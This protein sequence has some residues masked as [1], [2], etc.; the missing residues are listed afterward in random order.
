MTAA[1]TPDDSSSL[2]V[3]VHLDAWVVGSQSQPATAFY[4]ADY[5]R[6]PQFRALLDPPFQPSSVERP[7]PGVRLHW[8]LPDALTHGRTPAAG[9]DETV[10]PLVPNRWLVA[11]FNAG[12]DGAWACRLWV[13]E[14]DYT[15]GAVGATSAALAADGVTSVPL[16]GASQLAVGK[17]DRLQ[18][19]SPDGLFAATVV[20][21]EDAPRGAHAVGI[22][23]FDFSDIQPNGLDAGSA[24]QLLAGSPFL[25]PVN[26]SYM[27]VTDDGG[28]S[29]KVN[30]AS[31]GKSRDIGSWETSGGGDGGPLFLRAVGPG[32]VSF[33]AYMPTVRDVFS[34]TDYAPAPEDDGRVYRFTYMVVGWYSDPAA[35]DPLRG[36]AA[37]DPNVWASEEEWQAQTP[38]ERMQTLLAYLKWSVKNP[39]GAT[40][41]SPPPLSTSLYHG[42]VAGVEWPPPVESSSPGRVDPKSVHVAVGNTS[43]DA[44][45]ALVQSEAR[46]QAALDPDHQSEWTSAGDALARMMQAAMYDLLDQYG[47]PGGAA[48]VRQQIEQAWFGSSP[49]GTLWEAVGASPQ[50][51]DETAAPPQLTPAQAAALNSALAALNAAQEALNEAERELMSLQAQLYQM[52]W[53]VGRANSYGLYGGWDAGPLTSPDWSSVLMP[54]VLTLYP[55]IFDAT[56]RK[57]CAVAGARAALP[58]PTPADPADPRAP[59][60]WANANPDW[61]FP[62]AA[63][64][65]KS[66]TL[67]GLG[68]YLKASARPNFWHPND[69]VLMVSGLD[70]SRRHGED[71]RYNDDGTLTCRLPGQTIT[72]VRIP[73]QPDINAE[74]VA[75]GGVNLAPCGGYNSIPSVPTLV[76]EAFFADPAN[77]PAIAAAV[78]GSDASAV[79]AAVAGLLD[80]TQAAGVS[81]AGTPPAPFAVAAWEQGWAPLFLEWGVRY[82]PTGSDLRFSPADWQFDGEQYAWLGAGFDADNLFSYAGRTLLTPQAPL[83]FK[84]KIEAYLKNNPAVDSAQLERLIETVSAWDIL[85]QSL[86]GLT[87]QL[88]TLISQETFPPP[89]GDDASVPCPPGG[90]TRPGVAALVGDQYHSVPV[91]EGANDDAFF[92]VRTGFA[93]FQTLQVVDAFGQVY[94][95]DVYPQQGQEPVWLNT[96]QGF[97]PTLGQGLGLSV[98]PTV[99]AAAAQEALSLLP[100]GSFQLPPRLVQPARLDVTFLANDGSGAAA[101]LSA[102]PNP[103]CGW[104]L[105]NH[106]DGGVAVYDAGGVPLGELL[107]L[108][109]GR[110]CDNWRPRPGDPGGEPPPACPGDI[111]NEALRKVVQSIAAQPVAAFRD[112][113]NTIDETLWMVDPLGGR[114]DQ[115]L[116]VLIGRPLAVVQA[117]LRLSLHGE[118]LFNQLW[119]K[120][121]DDPQATDKSGCRQLKDTGGL[122]DL[123]FPV[124]LGSLELRNDGLIGYYLPDGDDYATF[125]AVHYPEGAAEG[126]A[127]LRQIVSASPPAGSGP[128]QGDIFV[129]PDGPPV[130][131][132]MLVDPR[133]SV[134]AYT[135]LLP[136]VSA[137][138]PGRLVEDF[139]RRLRVTFRTG[140]VIA[141]PGT[142]RLP[143]PA[144]Q[145]GVWSWVQAAP[146][147]QAAAWEEDVLVDADDQ[148]RLPD[149]QLQ[150]REGWLRLSD[151][152]ESGG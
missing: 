86:S 10:F 87:D 5:A 36:V 143:Q 84:A 123:S 59:D 85:S 77:A 139:I 60:P 129:K 147:G 37:Y 135:G 97:Q 152:N 12:D 9:G 126:D 89:P 138:L 43:A 111:R 28:V 92:P 41:E 137:A 150:L 42:L 32:N 17:G 80:G 131:V 108:P 90:E 29:F 24:V 19:V 142:M 70:R 117:T 45:A 22:E 4:Q 50:A 40:D 110:K 120:T 148:A 65:P 39:D 38:G 124:R 95:G 21:S 94:G 1:P 96:T 101:H 57:Y 71:G 69:P 127:Y 105:P 52:W 140:P 23:P 46:A 30:L 113:L 132:T 64:N 27:T 151:L 141:D 61:L 72:G 47:Q 106:L 103:V 125:Y 93:L 116:S 14:S 8:A 121:C 144:E 31:V 18:L 114:Q 6:L 102:D 136:V 7:E 49:G 67:A 53:K 130:T 145:H 26:P 48:L 44:L 83:T 58:D 98:A 133:G 2:L 79:A 34:F 78:A 115:F 75:G 62:D 109:P 88:V 20:A 104:L 51:S 63:G 35:G 107:A 25:D 76:A 81:W 13:V 146:P 11:R 73:G 149:Q 122:L 99:R 82:Y 128:Y 56:W 55:A 134:H 66:L 118:P 15:G 16:A 100:Y 33:A 91:V 74:T 3:P 68:L 54:F 112:L 119:D